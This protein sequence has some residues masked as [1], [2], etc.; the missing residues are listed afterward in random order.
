MADARYFKQLVGQ[1]PGDKAWEAWKADAMVCVIG[2]GAM[3][4]ALSVHCQQTGSPVSLLA[5]ELDQAVVEAHRRGHRHPALGVPIPT[6]VDCVE[7]DKWEEPLARADVI[8]V[9][10]SSQGISEVARRAVAMAAPD[11]TWVVATKGW[12]DDTL[13]SCSEVVESLMASDPAVA[14]LGGPALAPE[15]VAGVPTAIVCA[16]RRADVRDR[17]RAVLASP[18]LA[19]ATTDDVAG[20][21]TAAAYKNVAA[22][23]VGIC[24]GL[25]ER[26]SESVVVNR[27]ANTRAAVF[28]GGVL[29]MTRIGTA[30]GGRA[31]TMLGL[32][33]AGDLYVTCLGGRN[34]R[35]GRLLGSGETADQARAVIGSTVE[36]VG[37]TRAALAIAERVAIRL[38]LARAVADAVA[39][40][41][42][43]DVWLSTLGDLLQ[44]T[45]GREFS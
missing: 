42:S 8:I 2:A 30:L 17:V 11:A 28:A 34:S 32:A 45:D 35:F 26:Q 14:S 9:A 31:E 41:S 12:D 40:S 38:P 36:G 3:G 13:Q 43:P 21:E 16:S 22:I 33:G 6:G 5:T 24:E 25:S 7:A 4:T 18:A 27:Y 44:S 37:A 20:V 19:V 23:A 39:G 15:L 29:E 1:T 10:V